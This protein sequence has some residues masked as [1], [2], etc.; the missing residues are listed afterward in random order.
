MHPV[1]AIV[2]KCNHNFLLF[3]KTLDWRELWDG[4][5]E[6]RKKILTR[7]GGR[8]RLVAMKHKTLAEAKLEWMQRQFDALIDEMPLCRLRYTLQELKTRTAELQD[9]MRG[10]KED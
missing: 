7:D 9:I 3:R 10:Q 6:R 8:N 2:H 1:C 5:E 4:R